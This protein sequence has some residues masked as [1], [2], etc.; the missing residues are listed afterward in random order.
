[1]DR[2]LIIRNDPDRKWYHIPGLTDKGNHKVG[3]AIVM[4]VSWAL[5][6]MWA[7]IGATIAV[8]I[9]WEYLWYWKGHKFDWSDIEAT[10][11]GG[12]YAGAAI[13]AILKLV[14]FI[15]WIF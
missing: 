8:A 6:G 13:T 3:G 2:K 9:L 11:L 12:V 15:L 5:F 1:M 14:N 10:I 4:L 7:G